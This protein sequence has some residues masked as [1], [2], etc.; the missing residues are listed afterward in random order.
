MNS[1][2][3][4][5]SFTYNK[6]ERIATRKILNLKDDE[7]LLVF[8]SGGTALWQNNKQIIKIAKKGVKV[9]NLSKIEIKHKNILNKFVPY[10]KMASYLSAAD[11]AFIWRD[12]SSVN[13]VASP[14][15]FS[16]YLACGLPVIHNG[17][18]DL[19]NNTYSKKWN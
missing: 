8:A 7:A 1:C 12:K 16:E 2:L 13:E 11:V 14:V 15:K 5:D 3:V 19:I 10:H 9:L 17:T 4:D 6:V 18:I